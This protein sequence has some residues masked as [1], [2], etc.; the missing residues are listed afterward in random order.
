MADYDLWG[1]EPI[2]LSFH[3]V[4]YS[5]DLG[6]KGHKQILSE[7]SGIVPAGSLLA[8]MGPS[9][10]GK[11]SLLDLLAARNKDGAVEG[12]ILFNGRPQ[13]PSILQKTAYVMQDDAL[14]GNLT[15]RETLHYALRLRVPDS[16]LDQH[17]RDQRVN[18]LLSEL[19]LNKVADTRVGSPL[20]RGISGGERRRLAIGSEMVTGPKLVFLDE[21]TTGL[22]SH[23]ALR[24]I[25]SVKTLCHKHQV[26]A[27][28]TVHQPRSNIFGMFDYLLL[29]LN[30]RSVFFGPSDQ[31]VPYF[32][33]IGLK[34]PLYKNT[35][36]F[37]LEIL[38]ADHEE[39][40]SSSSSSTPSLTFPSSSTS[41][42]SS[43]DD[44]D[45]LA[46][47]PED[48]DKNTL[49][50]KFCSSELFEDL[51]RRL[52]VD[53]QQHRRWIEEEG[54]NEKHQ[55]KGP[56]GKQASVTFMTQ[57]IV[58]IQRTWKDTIRDSNVVYVRTFAAVFV[59]LLLGVIF[60]QDNGTGDEAVDRSNGILFLMCCFALFALPS[61][62]KFIE[63]RVLYTREHSSG[64]YGALPYLL[65]HF[66]VELPILAL[67]VF[68]Y[69]VISYYLIGYR[70]DLKYFA[71]FV[72]T[73]FLVVQV[74]YGVCQ[75]IAAFVNTN[76]VAIAVYV[77]FLLYSLLL[78][79]F[80][81]RKD[82]LPA[83]LSWIIYTSYFYYGFAALIMN[84]FEGD[85]ANARVIRSFD[86]EDANKYVDSAVLFVLWIVFQLLQYILLRYFNKEK[87]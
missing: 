49:P 65:S 80:I 42:S 73:E 4:G 41:S 15:P 43:P 23:N 18:D 79:G 50:A 17:Q 7:I 51:Q 82:Q 66:L 33:S 19:N 75:T 85:E 58:L 87:R 16:K 48:F 14:L 69:G 56:E 71:F 53:K 81:I 8:I 62:S 20:K 70:V 37:F 68:C 46:I 27:I 72:V 12:H 36:D 6:K 57:L 61:I 5:I 31:S 21:P 76:N 64:C 32:N 38:V 13:S 2:G 78:G 22:D 24:V 60:F 77:V 44:H 25:K 59:S 28:C 34:C 83:S 39:S 63:E 55:K 30:G 84:E 40:S 29:M 1:S 35:A 74:G 10:A 26:T 67:T 47:V 45:D 9:G 52:M 86:L 54:H 11:S 3:N